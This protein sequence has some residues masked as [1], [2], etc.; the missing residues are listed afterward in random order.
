MRIEDLIQKKILILDGAMGTMIQLEKL[1]EDDF[2]GERFKGHPF[3][4]QGN[5]EIISLTKPDVIKKIHKLYLDAGADLIE[6]NTFN[7]TTIS[8]SDYGTENLVDE[9]NIQSAKI[10][11]EVAD[12]YTQKQP[13][14]PRFV[15]GTM[16]PTNKTASISPDVNNPGKRGITFDELKDAYK[17][18][19]AGLIQG[20][21]DALMVETVFDTL[22]AKAALFA[23]EEHFEESGIRIP[24]M[25][26]VT[27]SDA[28]GRT[29]S[30][31]TVEAFLTS[32][33]HIPLLSI[34]LNCS[35]GADGLGTHLKVLSEKAPF[36]T[37]AHP[38]AGLPNEFGEY[39]QSPE[40]MAKLIEEYYK[41]GWVNIIGG[42]CGSKPQH[43]KAIADV[44]ERYNPRTI[45]A[46]SDRTITSGLE[47][48][49]VDKKDFVKIGERTN[50]TGSKKF[51]RLIREENYEEALSVALQQVENG[52]DLIDINVDE[53]MIESAEVMPRFLN[54]IVPEPDIAKVPVMLDSSKF[55]VIEAGLKCLQGKSV[56]NSISLKEGEDI[57]IERA[58]RIR[59]YGAA[60]VVMAFDEAGQADSFERRIEICKRSYDILVN[61][62]GLP[63]QEIIFDPNVLTVGTGMEEHRNYAV[64][65]FNT[66]KW[67]K[68]NLPHAKISGGVSNVSF[69]FRG[70]ND[71]REAINTAFLHH[72]RNE[73]M[74]M[75]IVNPA[76]MGK[77]KEIP[78]ELRTKVDD[79]L[80][81]RREDA[82]E[83]LLDIADEYKGIKK[84]D[85]K[86]AEWRNMDVKGRITHSL[87]K[88]ITKYV[89]Q[90]LEEVRH[91]YE[92]TLK[93]IEGPL[94]DG[95]NEV[96]DLFGAGK[97]FL[98]QVVK[99]ARVMKKAVNYLLP[100]IEEEQKEGEQQ[101]KGKILLAT[102]K[103]DVHD[104]GKN[105]VSVV[106]SCNNYEII[107]LGVM[108]PK[109]D[110]IEAIKK[111][112]PD[113][114]GLSGLITPSLDEMV[115]V[116]KAMEEN[117]M[118]IPLLLGGATTSV[119]HTA[120]KV[121][122]EY[123]GAVVHISDASR[124][125]PA[126]SK[127]LS[128][129]RD[130]YIKEIKEKQ[131]ELKKKHE[132]YK[133]ED[134]YVSLEEAR[135]QRLII[136][137]HKSKP[138]PPTQSG[139]HVFEDIQVKT[140]K[141]YIDWTFFFLGWGLSGK[142][143]EI[144]SKDKIGDEAKRLFDEANEML[145]DIIQNSKISPKAI[146][147]IFPA[148]ADMDDILVYKDESRNEVARRIPML[149]QQKVRKDGKP[150]L[151][152]SDYIAPKETGIKDYLGMFAVTTGLNTNHY[153]D[154][155]KDDGDS[156]NSI[157]FRLLTD[158]LAEALAEYLHEVV[159]KEYWGYSTNEKLNTLDMFREKYQGIRPAPGYPACPEH[160]LKRDIFEIMDVEA[161]IGIKLTETCVMDPVSSVSGLYF[162]HPESKYFRVG[163]VSKDQVA[164]YAKRKGMSFEDTEKWMHNLLNYE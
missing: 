3:D 129:E 164:D 83:R 100:F 80:L 75:G 49:D 61:K 9:I 138:V 13:D 2:R 95:M 140:L 147:G 41:K 141:E 132:D 107:D 65:F 108:I 148:N 14:K 60:V 40:F 29:L 17:Q 152:L 115:D 57:F 131:N 104:I 55:E 106:L 127:L 53:G 84:D 82:T 7:G 46:P 116:A 15:V 32:V 44:A 88:G 111:T 85:K 126:V 73:G 33:S 94:M 144:F 91:Q 136:D 105:I 158:R 86:E 92:Q 72:A 25:V 5:N 69:S 54:L 48:M 112:Q 160:T 102:V 156:Y 34:G 98:P 27:I 20:G 130:G 87:I 163:K 109:D 146:I 11:R 114:V 122:P 113:I 139:I 145:D 58:R 42:C 71:V 36:Y 38:N 70:N 12:E 133:K 64:D 8:Q 89:D 90:D 45:P 134:R 1:K 56:V 31:Q 77:Y 24:I 74:D 161:K 142:Y 154:E 68:N 97:M 121:A 4:L 101:T 78:D 153:I 135:K 157:M 16:G 137:W 123:S 93:V 128:K 151:A 43:I 47:L 143:P 125:V 119:M 19:A 99:S 149:R 118:D 103:G 26:S 37:S 124:S 110:I 155:Y 35:M 59:R 120:V 62:A 21:T 63:P 159:R 22:N 79:L 50:V 18:Q 52:A 96:G 81:N 51:A 28:S 117:N 76:S 6:T 39:D 23:I 150:L 67:I 162:S 30:G 10:A 66:V